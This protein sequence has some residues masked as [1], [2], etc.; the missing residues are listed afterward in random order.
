MAGNC[1]TE[2]NIPIQRNAF[3]RNLS[4][5][6]QPMGWGWWTEEVSSNLNNSMMVA[7]AESTPSPQV[8]FLMGDPEGTSSLV[9]SCIHRLQCA[10]A[11]DHCSL[12]TTANPLPAVTKSPQP[13]SSSCSHHP[14]PFHTWLSRWQREGRAENQCYGAIL[15]PNP[16]TAQDI[17]VCWEKHQAESTLIA[18]CK[19]SAT[20]CVSFKAEGWVSICFWQVLSDFTYIERKG[21]NLSCG[22]AYSLHYDN[23]RLQKGSMGLQ[24]RLKAHRLKGVSHHCEMQCGATATLGHLQKRQ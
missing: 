10:G 24:S 17:A 20:L 7:G 5:Y 11:A 21:E 16:W 1:D 18:L 4:V 8:S 19:I 23:I 15:P 6:W 22:L 13:P 3:T 9:D 14:A 12:S 2:T